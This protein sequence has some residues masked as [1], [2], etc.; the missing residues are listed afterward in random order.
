MSD[1]ACYIHYTDKIISHREGKHGDYCLEI[2][3][4][5]NIIDYSI[6]EGVDIK[7]ILQFTP[8]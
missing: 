3:V 5:K 6:A 2:Y 7:T 8:W 4:Y 1:E